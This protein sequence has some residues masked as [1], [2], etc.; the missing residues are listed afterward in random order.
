MIAAVSHRIGHRWFCADV[1]GDILMIGYMI[2]NVKLT[3]SYHCTHIHD[4]S[5]VS[6]RRL[7]K[8]STSL[9]WFY[10]VMFGSSDLHRG[11]FLQVIE[12][13]HVC[14]QSLVIVWILKRS[15]QSSIGFKEVSQF[16]I[17]INLRVLVV[18][19]FIFNRSVFLLFSPIR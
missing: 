2:I 13:D 9:P 8:R 6:K 15:A 1:S 5:A 18:W 17:L 19:F 4:P 11:E 16:W 10:H 14:I 7:G 3:S 12:V